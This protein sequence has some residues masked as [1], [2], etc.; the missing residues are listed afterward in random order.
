VESTNVFYVSP[1]GASS[2]VNI[3]TCGYTWFG[4]YA[5]L[6][7]V[8]GAHNGN[9]TSIVV[10]VTSQETCS[11][12]LDFGGTERPPI[13]LPFIPIREDFHQAIEDEQFALLGF[14]INVAESKITPLTAGDS[15]AIAL[16]AYSPQMAEFVSFWRI[17]VGP[18]DELTHNNSVNFLYWKV[19][20]LQMMLR[21]VP[22]EQ[23]YESGWDIE[24]TLPPTA[25]LLNGG[26]LLG[27]N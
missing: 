27:L 22:G 19:Q 9:Y 5:G 18:H 7:T 23:V 20:C 26:E 13:P 17:S 8:Y 14:D 1:H 10:E 2:P 12:Q 6:Y 15:V 11:A 4:L 3:S 16:A 25:S 21:R 24:F